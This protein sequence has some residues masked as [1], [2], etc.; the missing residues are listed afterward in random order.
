MRVCSTPGC[1]TLVPKTGPCAAHKRTT[2]QRGYGPAHVRLRNEYQ[3]KLDSGITLYCWRCDKPI[4]PTR[5]DLGHDD[6]DRGT[7]RGPECVPCNRSSA[8][9]TPS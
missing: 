6:N 7:Y 4:D 1:P 3:A 8:A 9:R 2:S 5:W